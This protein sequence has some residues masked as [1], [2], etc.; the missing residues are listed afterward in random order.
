VT[1]GYRVRSR[2]GRSNRPSGNHGGNRSGNGSRGDL[3]CELGRDLRRESEREIEDASDAGLR[4]DAHC[5]LGCDL[6]IERQTLCRRESECVLQG[7]SR[8]HLRIGFRRGLRAES[9][10]GCPDRTCGPDGGRPIPLTLLRLL[11]YLQPLRL[12]ASLFSGRSRMS[13]ARCQES[14]V[15]TL[16]TGCL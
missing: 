14:E 12:G 9:A 13:D 15:R 16:R 11:V 3:R 1:E 2:K 4:P 5:D 7:V 6:A 8:R 10:G